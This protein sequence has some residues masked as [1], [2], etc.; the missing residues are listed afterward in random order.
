MRSKK[1]SV[2]GGFDG[3]GYISDKRLVARVHEYLDNLPRGQHVDVSTMAE[4][5][6]ARYSEYGRRKKNAFR[7][8]VHKVYDMIKQKQNLSHRE[9]GPET[10]S[11]KKTEDIDD[12][13]SDPESEQS[14]DSSSGSFSLDNEDYESY[15]DTNMMNSSMLDLYRKGSTN[16]PGGTSVNS[17]PAGTPV[18]PS[19]AS[20]DATPAQTWFVDRTPSSLEQASDKP[21]VSTANE[22]D[23]K[24]S[25]DTSKDVSKNDVDRKKESTTWKYEEKK[26][27]KTIQEEATPKRKLKRKAEEETDGVGKKR[28]GNSTKG[29]AVQ[30]STVKFADIGGIES[31]LQEV[32]KLLIH[33]RHP[34]VYQTLGVT[35]PRGFLLHGPPGCGKTLLANAIAGE[36]ELPLLKIAATEIV[37]GVSGESEEKVRDLFEKAVACAPCILFIDEID[38]ITPKRE[39]AQREMERRIVAQ[40]LTCMDDLSANIS[41][42]VLVIGAT[43]RPD[44][45]DPALRRAGRFDREISM[46]IPDERAR[47]GILQ[48]LCQKLR[49][50]D[51]FSYRQLAHLT[52][53]YV[54]ADLSALCREAAMTAINRILTEREEESRRNSEVTVTDADV[55]VAPDSGTLSMESPG[56]R[57]SVLSWLKDQPPL[58]QEQLQNLSIQ[59]EDFQ[60]ALTTMQPSAKREGFATIPDVT[61]DD[62]GAL[63]D[64]R[65]ELTMAI[66]APVKHREKFESLGL[67]NPPGVLLA[68]PPGCG[69][70]LLAKAIANE[71]G[72][73]FISVKGPELLNMYVGESERAVRQVF[74]RARNSAPCVIFFDE[75][76]ALCPRRSSAGESSGAV[77]VVNQLLTEMDGLEARKQV[78]IMGATNRPDII[79]P[80]VLRP[81]RMDKLLFVG[82]PSEVDREAILNTI[83][84]HGTK[85]PI[86]EDV[87]LASIARNAQCNNFT[88]ADLAALVREA[89]MSA[90]RESV[91]H[92]GTA[93]GTDFISPG[94]IRI[95]LQHFNKAFQKVRPS[96]SEK[97]R[98]MYEKMWER[99]RQMV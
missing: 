63:Q 68:G 30:K 29:P 40:L 71:S 92:P 98:A 78:F 79:D 48:V 85:P 66:L 76:D 34:E 82:L 65:E 1:K 4:Q 18:N 22:I 90:L 80:A 33:L 13:S 87:C 61:W 89:A 23:D 62:I 95:N 67:V 11:E 55:S 49:L 37:S 54:G 15:K 47:A 17:A 84:K 99:I 44:F 16:T 42:H 19:S 74:Q 32:C 3:G 64:I 60:V 41:A 43:N 57:I 39:T 56:S 88:G 58:T 50:S 91:V 81:G 77:R 27:E 28:K 6:Q 94:Q 73:N 21:G 36:L 9:E 96:V 25:K 10:A 69:K 59:M 45:L 5:L 83:T 31:C 97:D 93:S 46:G 12:L 2:T 26:A 38:A 35:P 53:G 72:V 70:T 51:G 14:D 52:P 8:S 20:Q 24:H 75:L 7:A 86:D